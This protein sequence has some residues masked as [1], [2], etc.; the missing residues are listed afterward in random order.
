VHS[1]D[2]CEQ[3]RA[4]DIVQRRAEQV[5]PVA[6]GAVDRPTDRDAVRVDRD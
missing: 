4:L 6:V 2:L 5:E 1:V 3:T